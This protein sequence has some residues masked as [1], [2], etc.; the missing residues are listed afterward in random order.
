MDSQLPD[1]V[2]TRPID[3]KK[4]YSL[5]AGFV[6][7]SIAG[8]L[9]TILMLHNPLAIPSTT[10]SGATT[11]GTAWIGALFGLIVTVA[12]PVVAIGS[13]VG[14]GIMFDNGVKMNKR[15]ITFGEQSEI[16]KQNPAFGFKIRLNL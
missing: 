6:C 7:L 15:V 8:T 16:I 10:T 5:G 1:Y 11:E 4:Y 12:I 14:A 9:G 2:F 3:G 13:A